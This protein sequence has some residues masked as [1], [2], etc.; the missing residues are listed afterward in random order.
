MCAINGVV[1]LRGRSTE[2][3]VRDDA[4]ARRMN[5]ATSHRGPDGEGLYSDIFATLAH[6]RLAIL[7]LSSSSNQPMESASG[8][9]VIIFNGEIYNFKDLRNELSYP[10]VTTGDTEVILAAFERWGVEALPRLRG[11]FALAIWDKERKELVLAR[12]NAGIKPLYYVRRGGKVFFSS[13]LKGILENAD[14]DRKIDPVSLESYVRLRYVPG[15]QTM[16]Q[17][18]CK[19]LPG[20]YAVFSKEYFLTKRFHEVKL[21]P[22]IVEDRPLIEAHLRDLLDDSVRAH[23]ISDRPLGVFLSGG[24][25]STILL[26]SATRSK[27]RMETFSLRFEVRKE[28]QQ[29]KFNADAD[30]AQMTAAHYGATHHEVTL[31]EKE[32]VALLPKAIRHLDQPIANAT[33]I[34]QLFLSQEARKHIV[35]ALT[36][37]GGDELFGGY[38]RYRFNKYMDLYAHTPRS[39]RHGLGLLWS[40]AKKMD[41]PQ[42]IERIERFLFEKEKNLSKAISRE[43]ISDTPARQFESE[44]LEK[45]NAA[46]FT[47]LF[48]DADRR[49]WLV[50]EA[51]ART[52]AMTMA[53]SLEARI[54]FL[55]T[56]LVEYASR[57]PSH[58]RVGMLGESKPLLRSAFR[59]RLP[60]H[61][62]GAPKRGWFSPIAKW[63]RRPDMVSLAQEVLAPGF[64][65]PTDTVLSENA[66]KLLDAHIQGKT[67]ASP[68]LW[69]CITLRLWAQHYDVHF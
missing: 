11:M 53:A 34:A 6:K 19:L 5:V 21:Q 66:L 44:Y 26:D 46:D 50:D 62:H 8:R 40:P 36:G 68:A 23:M 37:D 10:F 9:Y 59:A 51:L 12:D 69:A 4:L 30:L 61:V 47:Q 39:L 43:F 28:E 64:H 32:F 41:T 25:D 63:L 15:S 57:I 22:L 20:T 3:R 52:D 31:S 42:G 65:A 2:E 17:S 35:V 7:D 49:S 16:I 1:D 33:A 29:E 24:L 13:E 54:P 14:I 45:R 27:G 48:M 55:D 67:Y 60:A 58:M 18:V 56:A 38:P